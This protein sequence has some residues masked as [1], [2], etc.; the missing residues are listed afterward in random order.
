MRT[1]RSMHRR[2]GPVAAIAFILALSF[3]VMGPVPPA[4]AA[5]GDQLWVTRGPA[6]SDAANAVATSPDGTRL[7]VTGTV[8]GIGGTRSDF[9][10]IAYDAAT[11]GQLWMSRYNGPGDGTD[12]PFAIA[13]SPD[14]A[15]VYVTGRI[16]VSALANNDYA[17]VAYEAA[18]GAQ[19]WVRRYSGPGEGDDRAESLGVS[20]DGTRVYVTGRSPGSLAV[21]DFATLA[22]DAA[23]GVTIWVRRYNDVGDSGGAGA[24]DLA[25][26]PD[27]ALVYVTGW[28]ASDNYATVAYDAVSGAVRWVR[29]Y[30]G[31]A[32]SSDIPRAVTASPDGTKVFVTG[33]S[34]ASSV[35]WDAATVAYDAASGTKLWTRRY[36]SAGAAAIAVSPDGA[37]V[38][39][40]GGI[41]GS[42]H[43]YIDYATVAYDAAT[44]AVL[45]AR[46]Y[47]GPEKNSSD[48]ASAI[49]V[50]PG[51]SRVY[52]TG[53]TD[54]Q[55]G[56]TMVSD[57][58][59]IAYKATTGTR[60]WLARY[61]S[62]ENV[63]DAGQAIATSPD[64]TRVYVTGYTQG[65]GVGG[66]TTIAYGTR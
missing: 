38:Y 15:R 41:E 65:P 31:P 18:T 52:V 12:E 64:G 33:S 3:A 11:G 35:R 23:T 43:N 39:V 58:T 19:V 27:G 6:G 49:A 2:R 22:Y 1:L 36:S 14:G 29:K 60:V 26:S 59:T 10:T 5:G 13:V 48:G 17:T 34:A 21:S 44:G 66:F 25:V 53:V 9:G 47:N 8:E 24:F 50:S 61:N 51:G 55:W 37:G 54:G 7:F 56:I 62:P 40:T 57:C 42:V 4:G 28:P 16:Y 20:P 32:N 45:W 30:N 63:A 46:T